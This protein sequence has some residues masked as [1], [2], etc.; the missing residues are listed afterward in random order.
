MVTVHIAEPEVRPLEI[1]GPNRP[2]LLSPLPGRVMPGR[3]F[4]LSIAK[5]DPK[6]YR[7]ESSSP[8][9]LEEHCVVLSSLLARR[10]K[11]QL[12]SGPACCQ[13]CFEST[14]VAITPRDAAF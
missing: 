1:R 5:Y 14:I 12:C 6:N 7:F 8:F 4:V 2:C 10:M 3:N 9:I 11:F 13:T